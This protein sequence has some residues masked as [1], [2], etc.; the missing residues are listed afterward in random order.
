MK[1]MH[2]NA[3]YQLLI[4]AFTIILNHSGIHLTYFFNTI[5][6]SVLAGQEHRRDFV[7]ANKDDSILASICGRYSTGLK[8]K[9]AGL[10]DSFIINTS[11]GNNSTDD[12]T[13]RSQRGG[14]GP[15]QSFGVSVQRKYQF[16]YQ[17]YMSLVS[18]EESV[19]TKVVSISP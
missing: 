13:Q 8:V 5:N 6:K 4:Y 17:V 2:S 19:Y 10:T 16:V 9:N 11:P 3:G 12:E 14:A 1:V 7:I 15:R 18:A